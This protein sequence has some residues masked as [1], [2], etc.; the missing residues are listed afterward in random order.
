MRKQMLLPFLGVHPAQILLTFRP[1]IASPAL[2]PTSQHGVITVLK[3]LIQVLMQ[4]S[5]NITRLVLLAMDD[6]IHPLPQIPHPTIRKPAV[7]GP[8]H[9]RCVPIIFIPAREPEC[10]QAPVYLSAEISEQLVWR[11]PWEIGR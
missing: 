8:D 1:A 7:H 5:Y 3:M 2:K 9:P 10:H 4:L 11:P 6:I